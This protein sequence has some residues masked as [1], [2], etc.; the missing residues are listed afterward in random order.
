MNEQ[1]ID[2]ATVPSTGTTSITNTNKNNNNLSSKNNPGNKN[3]RTRRQRRKKNENGNGDGNSDGNGDGGVDNFTSV[4]FSGNG[5]NKQHKHRQP[6]SD[7]KLSHSLSW[8]LRHAALRISLTIREDGYVPVQE[9]LD[10]THPKLRGATL[11]SIQNVVQ[12]S[13]KQRFK[14]E[15]RPKHL[16][17]PNNDSDNDK[18]TTALMTTPTTT[19]RNDDEDDESGVI[20]M[21]EEEKILCIRANQGHSI[22]LINPELL[23]KKMS[24][25]ELRLLQCIV[26]GTYPEAWESIQ[27]QGGG[28]KKMNRTH[29]HFASGL[30]TDDGVISG[31]RKNCAIYIYVDASKCAADERIQFFTSDNGVILTDGIG[32]SGVLPVYYFSHVTDVS[33]KLL[34]DNRD[35]EVE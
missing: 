10:S 29:I 27:K 4:S 32:N 7:K 5:N 34:L 16:Y 2:I 21:I 33:G 26:H 11:E 22:T 15:E 19:T 6:M 8:A 13:D 1:S 17:Y 23:L 24:P 35:A 14:L 20:E 31:M 18:V 25:D 9:I 30:P 28:L 12:T 3:K